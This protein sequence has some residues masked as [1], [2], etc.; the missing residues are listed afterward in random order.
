MNCD[1]EVEALDVSLSTKL[2]GIM[3][4]GLIVLVGVFPQFFLELAKTA[5]Q[6]IL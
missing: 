4:M 1:N 3:L 2:L 6:T 5:V